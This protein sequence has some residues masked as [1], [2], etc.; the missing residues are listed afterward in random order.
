MKQLKSSIEDLREIFEKGIKARHIT[1]PFCS[2]DESAIAQDVKKFLDTKNFDVIGV[3]TNGIINGYACRRDLTEGKLS[4]YFKEFDPREL[5]PDTTSILEVLEV[6]I[7]FNHIFVLSFGRVAG[8]ITRGDL[9]KV[10]IRM[11]LFSLISL[12]EMQMLRIIRERFPEN[13][14]DKLISTGRKEKV[15]ELFMKRKKKNEEIDLLDC[16]EFCDKY[17]IISQTE[18]ILEKLQYDKN[19]FC[20]LLKNLRKLRDNLAHVQDIITANWP[21]II[22]L[23]KTA[24]EF[25]KSCETINV[26]GDGYTS[27]IIQ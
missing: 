5:L 3:R 26:T 16:L 7:E 15:E 14:W 6:I 12:I 18:D 9:Q 20:T 11:W 23:S 17:T 4:K 22:I 1:E 27:S 10:P 8:I 24:E 2:F 25:L 19:D 13:S 21:S